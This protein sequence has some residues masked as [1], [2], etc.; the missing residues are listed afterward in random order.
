[1]VNLFDCVC[2]STV[3]GVHFYTLF[4]SQLTPDQS[5]DSVQFVPPARLQTKNY[6]I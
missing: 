4:F 1:M 5:V 6:N 2:A 3:G